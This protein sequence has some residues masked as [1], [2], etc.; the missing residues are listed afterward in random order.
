MPVCKP[1]STTL[2]HFVAERET[3]P[4][5]GYSSEILKGLKSGMAESQMNISQ[6]KLKTIPLPIPPLAEQKR[7][8]ARVEELMRLCDALEAQLNQSRTLGTHLLESMIHKILHP[9]GRS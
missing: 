1:V 6:P 7:I 9:N 5:I 8:V 3:K 4:R 2:P